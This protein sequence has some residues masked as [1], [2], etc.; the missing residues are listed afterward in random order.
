MARK[1]FDPLVWNARIVDPNTGFPTPEFLRQFNVSREFN[2][3]VEALYGIELIAGVG[4]SGGGVLGD[5]DDITFDLE[6]TAVTAGT[7]GAAPASGTFKY[8]RFTVD[9]QGR[10][11]AAAEN[12]VDMFID[13]EVFIPGKPTNSQLVLRI[14]VGRAC[15]LPA[16]LTG[17]QASARVASAANKSFD[18]KKNGSSVGSVD[19]NT[20]ASGTFTFASATS[21]A[22]GDLLE[23]V[24]PATADTTLED[25]SITLV[26]TR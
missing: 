13:R 6:N 12:T 24:A 18:I 4:L 1:N 9:A 14:E 15:T 3:D 8:A 21:F 25:I 11:T 22:A 19:F 2:Q 16:S 7:Y 23:I 26:A 10:L 17:S 5:L 20:S